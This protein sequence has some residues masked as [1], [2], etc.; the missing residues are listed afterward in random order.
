MFKLLSY[1]Y[2]LRHVHVSHILLIVLLSR[3]SKAWQLRDLENCLSLQSSFRR[4]SEQSASLGV[5]FLFAFFFIHV[6]HCS[7]SNSRDTVSKRP[8][9]NEQLVTL[10]SPCTLRPMDQV[11]GCLV[12]AYSRW[13]LNSTNSDQDRIQHWDR[14]HSAFRRL[15]GNTTVMCMQQNKFDIELN[16]YYWLGT[17][18]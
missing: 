13:T 5:S 16:D 6:S 7:W 1:A 18:E 9:T 8:A 11:S 14:F 12:Y 15:S 3:G 2:K 10:Y 17:S 4:I